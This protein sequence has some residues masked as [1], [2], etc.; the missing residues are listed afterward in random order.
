MGKRTCLYSGGGMAVNV[1]CTLPMH[2]SGL[3]LL[4]GR[5]DVSV[6]PD[7]GAAT[8]QRLLPEFDYLVVRT[9]LPADIF[10]TPNRLRGVVRHGTGLDLI[11]VESATAHGIPVAN[12]P[13]ANAEAVVEYCV[14][15][16]LAWARRLDLITSTFRQEGWNAARVHTATSTELSGK[17]VGIV[18][19]GTIGR[20]LARVCAEGFGM[21]VLG[22]QRN[23]DTLPAFV[24]G[25]DLE[26]L[27]QTSD[28]VVL[29][30][31]L[32]PATKGL[33]DLERLGCMKLSAVLINA[34]RGAIIDESALVAA[35]R[36][37]RIRG[38]ALDVFEAQPLPASHPY[39][40]LDNVM[41]TPH[42]GGLTQE[43]NATMSV[44]TARQLLQLMAGEKPTHL[45]NPEAWEASMARRRG[46]MSQ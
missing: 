18:G 13:G 12:V 19:V 24:E 42:V 20:S 36:D 15:S 44:G 40:A 23:L 39:W 5:A 31:P 2:A 1:L 26:T 11:P 4:E 43:S 3:A 38:A 29:T 10:E 25:T 6:A 22:H 21:R 37:K 9:L 7:P 28:Y 35:L 30:C 33:I 16:L 45:V 8:L 41:L 17:T 27:L 46:E 14:T 32:T 34:A